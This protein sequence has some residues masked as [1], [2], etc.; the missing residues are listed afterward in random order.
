MSTEGREEVVERK[1]WSLGC[2]H[3]V[4]YGKGYRTVITYRNVD[5]AC[6]KCLNASSSPVQCVTVVP[7]DA[8]KDFTSSY[9]CSSN[10][11]LPCRC[12]AP[13]HQVC[14]EKVSQSDRWD[15]HRYSGRRVEVV[16]KDNLFVAW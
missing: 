4:G 8:E 10:V 16:E 11:F 1:G 3:D 5:V 6:A 15:C 14:A 13:P 9:S 2:R 12:D 7:P